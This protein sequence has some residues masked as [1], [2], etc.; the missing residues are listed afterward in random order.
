MM[1]EAQSFRLW[2]ERMSLDPDDPDSWDQWNRQLRLDLDDAQADRW[3]DTHTE[4][5]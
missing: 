1:N 5:R 3:H 2:C 4:E